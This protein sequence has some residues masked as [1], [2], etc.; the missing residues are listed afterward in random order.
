MYSWIRDGLIQKGQ[1][2]NSGTVPIESCKAGKGFCLCRF[3]PNR[4][5]LLHM[6]TWPTIFLMIRRPPRS[7]LFPYTTL[8]RSIPGVIL[9]MY[10]WIRDGL[11][12]KGQVGNSGTVPIES[13]KAG[14]GFCLCRVAPNRLKLLHTA[15]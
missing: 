5:K 6:A 15:T 8:F 9:E 13:C 12:Q 7:T 10:S 4:L 14:K 11:I 2:G 3:A 1:V